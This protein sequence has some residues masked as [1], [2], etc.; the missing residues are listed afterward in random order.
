MSLVPVGKGL[1]VYTGEP[2]EGP[3]RWLDSPQAVIEFVGE[4]DVENTIALVRGGTTTFLT[5]ALNAGVKGIMTLQGAPESHL[6]ILSREYGIPCIMG[7]AFEKGVRTSRGET[8]PA[9]GVTV[10]LDISSSP[11]GTVYADP[12]A[13][14]DDG[15]GPEPAAAMDPETAAELG[16]LLEAYRGEVPHGEEGD[17][18]IR[19]HMATAVL[20]IDD[21]A[22]LRRELTDE[23]ADEL[24]YYAGWNMWDSLAARATEGESGL[25][26]RQEYEALGFVENWNR[27]PPLMR[28]ITE[29]VG[30]DG[31]AEIGATARREVGTKVN[32][33]HILGLGLAPAFGRGISAGLGQ[34][35]TTDRAE[36]LREALQFMRRL[37]KGVWGGGA[38]LTSMRGYRANVLDDHWIERFADEAT[39]LADADARRAFQLFSADT[40]LLGFLL[41]FDNR[42]GLADSGPYPLPGGRFMIVRDHFLADDV[43][44]WGDV[45]DGLPHAIT[46]AMIFEPTEELRTQVFDISTLFTQPAN[47]LRHIVG[48]G[49]YA[50]DRWD[51]PVAQLRAID[52][53]ERDAIRFRARGASDRLYRRIAAMNRR[54]KVMAGGQV[55]A[56]EYILPI[57][58]CAGVWE[59]LKSEH[60]FFEWHPLSS[61]A[62]Y[63]LVTGGQA[64]TLVPQLFLT[65]AGFPP[66]SDSRVAQPVEDRRAG[67]LDLGED[68]AGQP[69][70]ERVFEGFEAVGSGYTVFQRDEP[71]EG[72]VV[73]LD[74]P[75][76]VIDFC[77][78]GDVAGSIVLARG[79]TTTFLTPALAAGVAG[80]M[81]LQGTPESHLGIVSREYG[82]PALMGIQFTK[83]VRS[84]RGEVIPPDGVQ[85]RLDVSSAPKGT[86]WIEEGAPFDDSP[87]PED[88]EAAAQMAAI[89][90]MLQI[91]R[92]EVPHGIEG[93]EM[94]AGRMTTD[95]L[96]LGRSSL[97]RDLTDEELDDLLG[98]M[99]WE[100]WDFL[101]LRATEGESGLIPRQEYEA[102]GTVQV[103]QRYPDYYRWLTEKVGGVD[104]LM[105]LGAPQR[106]EIGNKA[107]LLHIWCTGF[108]VAFGRSVAVGLGLQDPGAWIEET[109]Q[110]IQFMRRLYAGAWGDEGPMLTTARR[111]SA[112]LLES[113]WL[114]RFKDERVSLADEEDRRRFQRFS[115][116]TE[117]FGFLQHLDNRCGLADTGPYPL[118]DG[119]YM[120]VRDHF[121]NETLYPWAHEAAGDLP[122]AVTQAMFFRDAKDFNLKL[123]DGS[124]LFTEPG[125]YLKNLTGAVVYARDQWHT[126]VSEV[127]RLDAA[128]MDSIA[129]RCA[130]AATGLYQTIAGWSQEEKIHNG[131]RVYYTDFLAPFIRQAGL[132]DEFVETFNPL[133]LDP[134]VKDA[135]VRLVDEGQAAT[136]VPQLFIAGGAYEPIATRPE[137]IDKAQIEQEL[138]SLHLLK[139]R[140]MAGSVPGDLGALTAAGLITQTRAG[141]MLTEEGHARHGALL[142]ADRARL[143]LEALQSIYQR[144]LAANQ[145]LKELS[146]RWQAASEDERFDLAGQLADIVDRV[147]PALR[148]TAELSS[149]FG[150]Y[151]PRLVAA[152]EKVQD[153]EHEYAV[154]PKVDSVHTVWMEIHE[155]YLLTL[156]ISREEEGSY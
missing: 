103:C 104:G 119:G 109:R 73:F 75:Q 70:E 132:Y 9:D 128:E 6:G 91:Y 110:A 16:R 50:R 108:P 58:R 64:T 141:L 18:H 15:T 13:P 25:I 148:R 5:P 22:A 43:Y 24:Q 126:P 120:I 74:T 79:G 90:E 37:Y 26:P 92:G 156:G 30:V 136:L 145:P 101:A 113:H 53:A 57:A 28:L 44:S 77:A 60:D 150:G 134:M 39:P 36:D 55:Y 34:I 135:Y 100:F 61:E 89:M 76:A 17:R 129:Q 84:S 143:D 127:R 10:R 86:V 4:G 38:M 72:K 20:E 85:V 125:N 99:G 69:K 140:G 47:Y 121:I 123:M 112:P 93:H 52:A 19:S 102:V 62:Y 40:E 116:S 33:L 147:Q 51:T 54:E 96:E 94:M 29:R 3:V 68:T 49:L 111:Y 45:T 105:E 82:I 11:A 153:G 137:P 88:P 149:R 117:M 139:V 2:V 67:P 42:L 1:T 21:D 12:A 14:V 98:Y 83:G 63:P 95:V 138:P 144:F 115:A 8:I 142:D 122:Y 118:P 106:R 130:D 78:S 146:S 41:H 7:V 31:L 81:T 80:V 114:E 87:I 133:E 154:S 155:D 124:T 66:L 46:Q 152:S 27:Y 59:E 151:H 131:G 23:E 35:S 32:L 107:N 97:D 71:A 56:T 65:G 48:V